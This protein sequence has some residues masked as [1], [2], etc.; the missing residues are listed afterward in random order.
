MGLSARSYPRVKSNFTITSIHI[1]TA[2]GC[3]SEG[4]IGKSCDKG[5]R[6]CHCRPNVQGRRCNMCVAGYQDFP[7]CRLPT[8]AVAD[9]AVIQFSNESAVLFGFTPYS[10][11]QYPTLDESFRSG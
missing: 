11:F 7:A 2:C 8:W 4:S 1:T 6:K 9:E 5:S 10:H 3:H